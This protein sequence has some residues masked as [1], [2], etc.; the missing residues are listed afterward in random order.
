[1]A[2]RI[3][4]EGKTTVEGSSENGKKAR[5]YDNNK[6][7]IDHDAIVR[8]NNQENGHKDYYSYLGNDDKQDYNDLTSPLLQPLQQTLHPSQSHQSPLQPMQSSQS[9][10]PLQPYSLYQPIH[11]P[12]NSPLQ[13]TPSYSP[14]PSLPNNNNNNS[15]LQNHR[16]NNPTTTSTSSSP[17]SS[18]TNYHHQNHPSYQNLHN[19]QL[20]NIKV[21]FPPIINLKELISRP[22]KGKTKVPSK[23]P[24]AFMI[25]RMQ[26]VKELHARNHRLPMRSISPSVANSW[27]E[28]PD[29]VVNHYEQ[30]ARDASKYYNLKYP[31]PPPS[32]SVSSTSIIN[33]TTTIRAPFEHKI[34][35]HDENSIKSFRSLTNNNNNIPSL[36]HFNSLNNY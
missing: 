21:P 3:E 12:L 15:S 14:T 13:H 11:H 28:E 35:L 16:L 5:D 7:E 25:Y 33:S 10:Q 29:S 30:L 34:P 22:R 1:M 20:P 32:T 2:R 36:P 8:Y 23:P 27:R 17:S 4:R 24:N 31:K 19:I 9:L 6:Q 18:S 26:Y